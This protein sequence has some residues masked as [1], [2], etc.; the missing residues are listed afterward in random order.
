MTFHDGNRLIPTRARF[1]SIFFSFF[2]FFLFCFFLLI[3]LLLLLLFC[4]VSLSPPPGLE[5]DSIEWSIAWKMIPRAVPF[6]AVEIIKRTT[7]DLQYTEVVGSTDGYALARPIP[8]LYL[9]DVTRRYPM[10]SIKPWNPDLAINFG[11]SFPLS[12]FSNR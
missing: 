4:R 11:G 3:L 6:I 7:L 2:F 9:T 5:H 10:S 12:Q 1:F 8:R